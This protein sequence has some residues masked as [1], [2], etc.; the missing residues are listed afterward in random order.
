MTWIDDAA[1]KL[2]DEL[3]VSQDEAAD[4]LRR[5]DEHRA[6]RIFAARAADQPARI[7][8][9]ATGN[10]GS[11]VSK[12][13]LAIGGGA[14]ALGL[15]YGASQVSE[16]LKERNVARRQQ[17]NM[18]D[19]RELVRRVMEAD[20]TPQQKA[21]VLEEWVERGLFRGINPNPNADPGDASW[22][23]KIIPDDMFSMQGLVFLL[24]IYFMGKA[25]ITALE[26]GGGS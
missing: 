23:D 25:A 17:E 21:D 4:V 11:S 24:I 20:M 14:G 10:I 13:A 1:V 15:G 7:A 3:A 26:D 6:S 22:V 5:M 2:A 12:S 18:A 9:E 8:D 16:D 19:Q